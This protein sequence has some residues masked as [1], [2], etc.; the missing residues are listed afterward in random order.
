LKR[1]ILI[2]AIAAALVMSACAKTPPVP[3]APPAPPA[4]AQNT[5]NTET[6]PGETSGAEP[7][8]QGAGFAPQ[9]EYPGVTAVA[10]TKEAGGIDIAYP[11]FDGEDEGAAAI[12]LAIENEYKLDENN[13]TVNGLYQPDSGTDTTEFYTRYEVTADNADVVSVVFTTE[14]DA[15][16]MARPWTAKNAMTFDRK[17]GKPIELSLLKDGEARVKTDAAYTIPVEE[18]D[19]ADGKLDKTYDELKEASADLI[20]E[21][22]SL[23]FSQAEGFYVRGDAMGGYKVGLLFRVSGAAG[24]VMAVE[25]TDN[26]INPD[27]GQ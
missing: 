16:G 14:Q 15:Q 5:E 7:A 22:G 12:N 11:K 10:Y 6:P 1:T 20:K 2:P 17:T 23:D 21:D 9:P 4:G 19:F 3:A 27:L 24:D 26:F 25:T 8:E 18:A 13:E